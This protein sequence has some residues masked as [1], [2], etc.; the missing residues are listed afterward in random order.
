[1]HACTNTLIPIRPHIRPH[2]RPI[3]R[4]QS[5][6]PRPENTDELT[7]MF[8]N[9]SVNHRRA[10]EDIPEYLRKLTDNLNQYRYNKNP[11]H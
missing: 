10:K 11:K 5:Y 4:N 7:Y 6:I 3:R 9:C 1:M 2:I 8:S